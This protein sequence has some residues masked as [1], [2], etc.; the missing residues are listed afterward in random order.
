[1]DRGGGGGVGGKTSK[2]RISAD[3]RVKQNGGWAEITPV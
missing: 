1:M 3:W 2:L